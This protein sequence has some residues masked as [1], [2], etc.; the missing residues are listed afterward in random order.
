MTLQIEGVSAVRH[1]QMQLHHIQL[2]Y[3]LKLLHVSM[4]Q[5]VCIRAS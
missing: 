2:R 5:C 3:F 1:M 4:C